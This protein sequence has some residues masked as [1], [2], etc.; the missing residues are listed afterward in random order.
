MYRIC[1]VFLTFWLDLGLAA[2]ALPSLGLLAGKDGYLIKEYINAITAYGPG[3][4]VYTPYSYVDL[5]YDNIPFVGKIPLPGKEGTAS[6]LGISPFYPPEGNPSNPFPPLYRARPL[7]M[8]VPEPQDVVA[9][10]LD[11]EALH[12]EPLF[13]PELVL[14]AESAE[15]RPT[16]KSDNGVPVDPFRTPEG[17][18]DWDGTK[19]AGLSLE[20]DS[21]KGIIVDEAREAA[22]R[23][24]DLTKIPIGVNDRPKT[25][26]RSK[27]ILL[28]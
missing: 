4:G 23:D 27:R 14:P 21:S 11:E 15:E 20:D 13:P 28:L 19:T 22:I 10:P 6:R 8:H 12:G 17:F 16:V 9:V 25:P 3:L 18:V 5:S 7:P 2:P 26:F 24:N 1:T